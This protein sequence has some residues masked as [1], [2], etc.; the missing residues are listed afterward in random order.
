MTLESK[1]M[2]D[3]PTYT[4][5]G[6][7]HIILDNKDIDGYTYRII[8]DIEKKHLHLYHMTEE[9]SRVS[10]DGIITKP[11]IL[12]I[13]IQSVNNSPNGMYHLHIDRARKVAQDFIQKLNT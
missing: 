8:C 1:Y 12:P 6:C 3:I 2:S 5:R 10:M 9:L 13:I 4:F 7:K 11:D